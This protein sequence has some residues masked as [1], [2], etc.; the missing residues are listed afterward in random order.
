MYLQ[1]LTPNPKPLTL[2]LSSRFE[3]GC[4]SS[5]QLAIQGLGF[6][7]EFEFP[8]HRLGFGDKPLTLNPYPEP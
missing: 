5:F 4:E 6:E 7:A 8:L 1:T 3:N 2:K